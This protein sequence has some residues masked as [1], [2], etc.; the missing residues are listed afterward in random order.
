MIGLWQAGRLSTREAA[1][2]LGLGY[3]DYVELLGKKHIAVLDGE[4][5]E[6]EVTLLVQGIRENQG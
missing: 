4:L 3:Y 6:G 1:A 2:E 5:E